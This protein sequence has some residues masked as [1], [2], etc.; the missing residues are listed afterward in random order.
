MVTILDRYLFKEI[1]QT[2]FAVITVL[3][4]ILLSNK[5][6]RFLGEAASG[7]LPGESVFSLLALTSIQYLIVLLPVGLFLGI[8]LALGRL[9]H[10]S[11]MAALM[12]CGAGPAKLYRPLYMLAGF[13]AFVLLG[14]S[15]Y[16]GP[17]SADAA[18]TLRR[19]AEQDARLGN[20]ESGRFKASGSSGGVFYTERVS[21]DGRTLENIFLESEE[22]DRLSVV[23]ARTAYQQ[24]DTETGRR[25][26]VMHNGY[27]YDGTPGI[28][29]FQ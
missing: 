14:L 15:L 11:E 7:K 3:L 2:A 24:A 26:L 21:E 17:W 1:T 28:S 9:Y 25:I 4:L 13:V 16:A 8:M 6:A 19:N 27:R 20:F 22:E 12:A 5:F 23:T 10:D 29:E 18:L